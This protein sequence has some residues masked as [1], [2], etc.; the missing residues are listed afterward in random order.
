M[1][2]AGDTTVASRSGVVA[3]VTIVFLVLSFLFLSL[4][5][6]SRSVFVRKVSWDDYFILLAWVSP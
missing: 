4:R 6:I 3:T 1:S 2:T 5:L